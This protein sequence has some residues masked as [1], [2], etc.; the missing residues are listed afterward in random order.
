MSLTSRAVHSSSRGD[1]VRGRL[2]PELLNELALDVH[3][4]VQLLDH[5]HRDAD[6]AGLV[7]DRARDGLADPP[8]GVGGEL[9]AAPVVELLDG[10][11]QPERPLLDQVEERQA[12]AQVALGD[13]DD[14]AQVGLD[15]LLLGAHVAALDP[16]R[17]TDLLVG[18][19]QVHAADRAQVE[20]QRVEAR[21]DRQVDLGLLG[22]VRRLGGGFSAPSARASSDTISMPASRR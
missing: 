14:E 8:G 7:G 17:E 2:A 9:V 22:N 16:L 18:R 3:D 5:V 20:A 4:L 19:E 12:A 11:D 13:R 15:H 21:L 10:A 1:L 6:G